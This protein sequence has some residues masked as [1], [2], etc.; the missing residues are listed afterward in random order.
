VCGRSKKERTR[1]KATILIEPFEPLATKDRD[2]L[3]N[4]GERLI[5]FVGKGAEAFE[6]RF[7][8]P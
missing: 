5:R 6:V 4:E 1:A 2:S 8:E 3:A 7:A